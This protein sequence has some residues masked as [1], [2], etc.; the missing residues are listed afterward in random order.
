MKENMIDARKLKS[1]LLNKSD[2]S[3]WIKS[4][5]ISNK[6]IENRDFFVRE[7]K[8]KLLRNTGIK[9]DYFLTIEAT[10]KIILNYYK[11]AIA[12]EIKIELEKGIDLKVIL[13]E[14]DNKRKLDIKIIEFKDKEYPEALK[15]IKDPPK[16]LYVK[17]NIN[18]LKECGIAVIG[19]RNCTMEGRKLC[20]NFT[21][22]LVGYNFNIISGLAKGIDGCAHKACLEVKG[23]TIAVLPSGFYNVFPKE[24]ESLLNKILENGGT[25]ISE[26]PPYFEKTAESC[27][28]RNRIISGLAIGTLVV[29]AGKN[30]GTSIT[31]GYANKENKK[32]FCIPASLLN[33][34]GIGTNKMIKDNK[35]K[36]VTEVEDIIKEFPELKLAKRADFDFV[37]LEDNKKLKVKQ[38]FEIT[39][40]NQEVYN[41]LTKEP[42]TIDEISQSLNK[43]ISEVTYKLSLLELEGAIEELPGKRFKL[44]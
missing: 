23:K 31:V 8:I 9:I 41:F 40:E 43:P 16:C 25:A 12:K 2:F 5:I 27:R 39:E 34:K 3:V 6:L 29:E 33:S 19:T 26:Y 42:K 13:D 24:N 28:E 21:K 15:K 11:N 18:N 32:V 44:K 38:D 17:G 4:K 30:S 22:N 37:S 20:R 10:K 35:A 36:L 14:I 1:L 7:E